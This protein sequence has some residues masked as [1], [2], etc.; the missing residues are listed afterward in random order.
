MTGQ[1]SVQAGATLARSSEICDQ[2]PIVIPGILHRQ[3]CNLMKVIYDPY[4]NQRFLTL[5]AT[6]ANSGEIAR[7]F[8]LY[9]DVAILSRRFAMSNIERWAKR[10]LKGVLSVSA[11][12]IAKGID[13]ALCED[14]DQ[15]N[16][17]QKQDE[18]AWNVEEYCAF[19]FMDAISYAK[20]VSNIRLFNDSLGTLQYYCANRGSLKFLLGIMRI[21]GLRQSN[22]ALFGSIFLALLSE[23]NGVWSRNL[24]THMDRMALFSG[25]SYLS[26]LP[27]S[28][29]S[30][31]A[32]LFKMPTSSKAFAK[33]FM[34]G[35]ADRSPTKLHCRSNF[36]AKWQ[37]SFGEDYYNEINSK[38]SMTAIRALNSLLSRRIDFAHQI[39]RI[40]CDKKCYKCVLLRLD[41]SIQH[42]HARLAEYY[43]GFD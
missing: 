7:C 30:T 43:K 37:E 24:F 32:P 34:D 42:V 39:C 40:K 20:A 1:A 29:K 13:D 12:L 22:P 25:Q 6:S 27:E 8:A 2:T 26:P 15:E 17:A 18:E 41:E 3:F 21:P 5:P 11:K 4:S 28:L 35:S 36:F 19:L 31:Y 23:G 9:L 14:E 33:T 10:K 38:D 16:P